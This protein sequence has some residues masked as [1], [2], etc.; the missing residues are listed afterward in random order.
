MTK[1]LT[2]PTLAAILGAG[3]APAAPAAEE[4][5]AAH[6]QQ[7]EDYR[8]SR[9]ERLRSGNGWLTLVGLFW[10]E[11]GENRFGSNP[12]NPIVFP[13]GS[14]PAVAGTLLYD[15][16][17]VRLVPAP[18]SG[19]TIEGEPAGERRLVDDNEE[20]TDLL[21]VG[22]LTFYIVRRDGRHAVRVK[23]PE[24]P[25][26]ANF[27]GLAYF[28]IDVGYRV[29]GT[30]R[31]YD[32]LREV[33][34]PTVVGT[35]QKML[36]P[37]MIEFELAGEK[38]SLQPLISEPGETELFI[39]LKDRTSGDETYGAGRYL[40]ATLEGDRVVLDFNKA[41]NPPCVF[42]PFATCP[43]PPREN[44]LAVRVEAGEKTYAH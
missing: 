30:L 44:H 43:L 10:L 25:A 5:A 2:I 18:D 4:S 14:A 29:E 33:Q 8:A 11:S 20:G 37:G 32:R 31:P 42:T 39:I 3:P 16:E 28:P 15:G 7:V 6:V 26:R 17:T 21:K 36:A 1:M 38:L 22:R 27:R 41:Y 9:E 13:E 12:E 40:Y 24:S 35:P 23:D 19:I 34:V